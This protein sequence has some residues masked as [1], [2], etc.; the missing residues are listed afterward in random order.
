MSPQQ[1][2]VG[3][4]GHRH[5]IALKDLELVLFSARM[6]RNN[7]GRT[8]LLAATTAA[9][10]M[11]LDCSRRH[12]L[13][14][15]NKAPRFGLS[16]CN[17]GPMSRGHV[18]ELIERTRLLH[19]LPEVRKTWGAGLRALLAEPRHVLNGGVA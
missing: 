17:A 13:L 14:G 1:V 10:I 4:C 18:A 16:K 5:T 9:P 12:S 7:K 19:G 11:E 6:R 15:R 8:C 3:G 2:G